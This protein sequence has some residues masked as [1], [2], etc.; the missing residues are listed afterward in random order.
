M[1]VHNRDGY[2]LSHTA[3]SASSNRGS[4]DLDRS[5]DVH[6]PEGCVDPPGEVER[7]GNQEERLL[8]RGGAPLSII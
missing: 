7:T 2:R 5:R 3:E 8:C 6:R 4:C 1:K